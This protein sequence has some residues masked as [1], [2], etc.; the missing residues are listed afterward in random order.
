MAKEK[1]K[2]LVTSLSPDGAFFAILHPDG[3]VKIWDTGNATV[4][5]EWKHS[6]GP[7]VTCMACSFVGKKKKELDTVLLALGT[8]DVDVLA[9]DA[10]TGGMKWKSS[11]C[12]PGGVVGLAF[13][14]KG[15]NLYIIGNNGMASKVNSKTGELILEFKVSKKPT[16]SLAFSSDEK[17]LAVASSRTRVLSLENGKEL[18]KFP[19]DLDPV[20]HISISNNT[21]TII[22]SGFGEKKLNV[23]RCNLSSKSVTSGPVLSM[24]HYPLSLECEDIGEKAEDGTVILA[25]SESGVAYVWNLK[26]ISPDE[27][28]PT[29]I[30]VKGSEQLTEKDQQEG[31]NSKKSRSSILAARLHD[32]KDD[33][34]LKVIIAYG[35]LD[36]P[37]FSIVNI[38][39]SGENIVVKAVDETEIFRENGILPRKG[40]HDLEPEAALTSTQNKKTKKKRSA[41]DMDSLA[42]GELDTDNG[43]A[44]DGV[45]V[46]DDMN[47][48]TMGEKLA[49]LN[50]HDNDENKTHEKQELPLAKPPSADS[51]N[52]L[53]K[54][55]LRAEDR[56]LLLDC[57]YTQDEKVIAN[58]ISQ[59]NPSDVLK[60]LHSLLTILDSRGAILACALPWL[61]SL[62]LQHASGIM[63][64][65]SS[66]LALNSLYQ[67]IE[68][69]ISTF[70]SALQL[71]SRLDSIYA[72]VDDES[73]ENET[74]IPV[75][76]EDNDESD[77]E[78]SEEAMETDQEN[79]E[80]EETFGGLSDLEKSDDMNE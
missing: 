62:L 35:L 20:Q 7:G 38:S 42:A 33:K 41:S 1:L 74:V 67:I 78:E 66:L 59:L 52:V 3:T 40:H 58:S 24:R 22:T 69:R 72:M 77:A 32:L 55:A 12:H 31:E 8:N 54:Q 64:Q 17:I 27:I 56:A 34:Q 30:T 76:Y 70:H 6:D 61:K 57:L 49:S 37:Q 2:S 43:E 29:K 50:L 79:E 63:S 51:V 16:S 26:S 45:L 53:L 44:M 60:L 28:S 80:E 75:I 23:W 73:E 36:S 25:V 14:N 68:S 4:L 19:D 9:F 21:N 48:P 18:L 47:E 15:R 10:L 39:N 65:D 46:E 11:V 13:A 71:S 5:A